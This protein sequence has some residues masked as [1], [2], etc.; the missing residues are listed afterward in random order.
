M[1]IRLSNLEA[2]LFDAFVLCLP[3][4]RDA[5][6]HDAVFNLEQRG[7][8]VFFPELCEVDRRQRS[9]SISR[10][11]SA[12]RVSIIIVGAAFASQA[13][14]VA[15][16]KELDRA[17]MRVHH[18]VNA[19]DLGSA[20]AAAFMMFDSSSDHTFIASKIARACGRPRAEKALSNPKFCWRCGTSDLS[21]G[22][23]SL[24]WSQCASCADQ[25]HLDPEAPF[26]L[27]PLGL[28]QGLSPSIRCCG[29][30]SKLDSHIRV[31]NRDVAFTGS[32]MNINGV[33]CGCGQQE[34]T[35][36]WSGGS[37]AD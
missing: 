25:A 6:V 11:L 19:L 1:A 9:A 34:F 3:N 17:E 18:G 21:R 16:A 31:R 36:S 24:R 37:V 15:E 32:I 23:F 8:V 26:D 28:G 27:D 33:A 14:G 35:V 13:W 29:C 2:R 5:F 20:D 22:S 4:D 12:S 30:G 10:G 7:Y